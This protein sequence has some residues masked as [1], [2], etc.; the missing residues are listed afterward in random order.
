MEEAIPKRHSSNPCA[1]SYPQERLWFLHQFEPENTAYSDPILLEFQGALNVEALR[2][3]IEFVVRRHES[4]RTTFASKDGV[5]VQIVQPPPRFQIPLFDISNQPDKDAEAHRITLA[6]YERAFNLE[7]DLM[8]RAILVRLEPDRHQLLFTINHIATD[9]WSNGILLKEVGIAY[10]AFAEGRE[11]EL[12]PLPLQYPDFAVWQRQYLDGEMLE[13]HLEYWKSA[14]ADIPSG[15]QLLTDR[16]R[17]TRQTYVGGYLSVPIPAE[18]GE[19]LQEFSRR[20]R[21]TLSMTV[22]ACFA[23]LLHRYTDQD[24][25]VFGTPV[26]NRNRVEI[27]ALIG[28]F[29]NT[30]A[31]RC[32]LSGNPTFRELLKQVRETTLNAYSHQE[33]PFEKLVQ[34]LRPERSLSHSPIFQTLLA[35]QNAPSEPLNFAGLT[36]TKKI[37]ERENAQFDLS[38]FIEFN[39]VLRVAYSYN[40]DL[41]DRETIVRLSG[42]FENILRAAIKD[43]DCRVSQLPMLTDSEVRQLSSWEQNKQPYPDSCIH[44]I[45]EDV[46]AQNPQSV[47]LACRSESL[48]FA[49]LNNRANLLAKRLIE[50]G[51]QP[52][53]RVALIS[54][55]SIDVVVGML[56]TL[57]VGAAFVPI[58]P[59]YPISRIDFILEDCGITVAF[60]TAQHLDRV[61]SRVKT[62][63]KAEDFRQDAQVPNPQLRVSPS[64]AA[65]IIFTSGSTGTPKGVEVPHRGIVRLVFGQQYAKFGPDVTTLQLCSLSFDVSQFEIWG[66][67]L[68]GAKC[69]I[70]SGSQVDAENIGRDIREQNVVSMW[71]TTSLFNAVIEESPAVLKPLKQLLIGGEALSVPHIRRALEELPGTQLIDGYGPTENSVLSNCSYIPKEIPEVQSSIPIGPPIANTSAYVLD[72]QL[73]RVPIGVPGELYLG[74]DGLAI[75]YVNRPEL[76]AAA[77]ITNPIAPGERL[78]KSGDVCRWLPDGSVD[79]LGRRDGQVKIRGFR[80]ELGE[81]EAAINQHPLVKNSVAVVLGEGSDR[82]L[83][84]Y[85]VP[86]NGDRPTAAKLKEYLRQS[87]PEYMVPTQFVLLATLP[88][89]ESG[90]VDKKALPPPTTVADESGSPVD[91]VE[92]Q[93]KEIW[94]DALC[95]SPIGTHQDFFDLGGH[96]LLATKLLARVQRTLGVRLPIATLF[97]QPT[98]AEFAK[99][100]RSKSRMLPTKNPHVPP[101]FWV[102]GGAFLRA[103]SSCLQPHRMV[104]PMGLDMDEWLSL[105]RPYKVEDMA[106]IIARHIVGQNPDGPYFLGGWCYE[107][108]LAYETAL[109]LRRE[110]HRVDL[111]ILVDAVTPK[112]RTSMS[113]YQRIAA[114][115]HREVFHLRNL[116]TLGPSNWAEYLRERFV[117]FSD[118]RK[119]VHWQKTS[120]IDMK[121]LT[122]EDE[123]NRVLHLAMLDYVPSVY[124]G[125]LLF[126]QAGNRPAGEYWDLASEWRSLAKGKSEWLELGGDH[127]TMLKP[128]NIDLLA[129]KLK[130]ALDAAT[131][132]ERPAM[133]RAAN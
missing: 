41:F 51:V 29:V 108:V 110:G 73:Q 103:I 89:L 47:A 97:Q 87:L 106:R 34:A 43:P 113:T 48:T 5:A 28:F 50:T 11:P 42:H 6:E 14:L 107:G 125:S 92:L 22:Y 69:A 21:V 93:L 4:L 46:A 133:V 65:Y 94:E 84:A 88:L 58:D 96:S 55:R 102:G 7:S 9:G 45:F 70:F 91:D 109:Q 52:G 2:K 63:L 126:C 12:E 122:F 56:A 105:Q 104:I 124:E 66:S 100:V 132:E 17:P 130:L 81:V 39:P 112:S 13:E 79:Y 85:V 86:R 61:P 49:Q 44:E 83:V 72:R 33:L 27:E 24:T 114:R 16:P 37:F 57:K 127:V 123:R 90:K 75:G 68:H 23:A 15:P 98:I 26:A 19:A 129:A 78:Y 99:V 53:H 116:A 120:K 31:L 82:K 32:D 25:V 115:L 20:E 67:L 131:E 30:L 1:L 80:V 111:L 71:L 38:A 101:L 35:V 64:D 77:F 36:A 118:Y 60:T 95:I 128:P 10:G 119:R 8:I 3:A 54:H 18:L 117:D 121:G 76:N 62:I 74:G 59:N 40:S